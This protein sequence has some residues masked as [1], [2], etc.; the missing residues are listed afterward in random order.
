MRNAWESF[1]SFACF[2]P[3]HFF[4]CPAYL[5]AT[6]P[7]ELLKNGRR[8]P[9]APGQAWACLLATIMRRR[10]LFGGV[11]FPD[12]SRR[13]RKRDTIRLKNRIARHAPML[14]GLFTTPEYMDAE[15]QWV[16]FYFLSGRR[17]TFFN[18]TAVTAKHRYFEKTETLARDRSHELAPLSDAPFRLRDMFKRR[19]DGNYE[20]A[21]M[22]ETM[23][24][25][26]G[27]RTRSEWIAAEERRLIG[28]DSVAVQVGWSRDTQYRYGIGLH[29]VLDVPS[30]TIDALN[31][32][33]LEF[34][35]M[36]EADWCSSE[37]R[38]FGV[39]ELPRCRVQSNLLL[40]PDDWPAYQ[41]R[42]P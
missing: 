34:R 26:F 30:V 1:G 41:A 35:A 31:T 12:Q 18:A 17:N 14:G 5:H 21:S 13:R 29:V 19:P 6:L 27:G 16:D 36:G 42:L 22:P 11:P 8:R 2:A 38:V 32:F 20:Y 23:Q 25:V 24:P 33:I 7:P 40:D 10:S 3:W 9:T 15:M 4:R 39:A 28:T 37:Y